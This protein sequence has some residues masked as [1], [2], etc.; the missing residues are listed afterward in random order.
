MNIFGL[1]HHGGLGHSP[2]EES[3][4]AVSLGLQHEGNVREKLLNERV[5]ALWKRS[6]PEFGISAPAGAPGRRGIEHMG[7]GQGF[8]YLRGRESRVLFT[9]HQEIRPRER[10]SVLRSME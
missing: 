4:A 2:L 7:Q 5:A 1:K 3:R 8:E 9:G 10:S 6:E